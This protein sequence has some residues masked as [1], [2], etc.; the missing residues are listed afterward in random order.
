[1]S[2][3]SAP[4]GAGQLPEGEQARP[5]ISVLIRSMGRPSLQAALAS[6]AAQTL[7]AGLEVVLVNAAGT[8]HPPVPGTVGRWPLRRVE[9]GRP[10]HRAAAA[11]AA[12]DAA[13]GDWLL[14]LDDDDTLDPPHLGRLLQAAQALPPVHAVYTGVRRVQADGQVEGVLDEAFDARRLWLANFLPIHAVLFSRELVG[15]GCRFDEAFEVYE[16]WDFWHQVARH[17]SLRHVDGVSATYRLV[18]DSG[19]SADRDEARSL[20]HRQRF[21]AKWLPRLDATE[22]EQVAT[23]AELTR[24]RLADLHQLHT[25]AVAALTQRDQQL[26]QVQAEAAAAHDTAA[27]AARTA[28]AALARSEQALQDER[29]AH[30]QALADQQARTAAAQAERDAVQQQLQHTQRDLQLAQADRARLDAQYHAMIGSLSWRITAPL[31]SAR[32]AVAGVRQLPLRLA[33]GVW[34]ALPLSPDQRTRVKAQVLALPGGLALARKVAPHTVPVAAPAAAPSAPPQALD[35]QQIRADAEAALGEFLLGRERIDLGCTAAE[36]VV[37]VIAIMFNQAGLTRLCLQALAKSTGV[38]FETL[39]V[40]NGSS[41]RVPQLLDRVDGATVLRPGENLGFLRAVNLAAKQARGRYLLLLNNDAMVEPGTLAAAVRR[42]DADPG[43]AAVGGPILLWDGRLQEAGSIVWR[44]GSCLGYGRG[45]DPAR[46]EYRYV[47]DVDYCSGAFLMLRHD[48]WRRLGGFDDAYA[49]AYYE[50]SDFCVRLLEGGQRIVY[51][52]AVRV[53]HFEFASEVSSGWALELQA[54]NRAL[55]VERHQTFLQQQAP[56]SAAA[57]LRARQRVQPGRQRILVIDDRVPLPWLGRGYPRA[58]ELLVTLAAEGHA[59]TFYPLLFA[60]ETWANIERVVP[61]TV[62]IA[63]DRGVSGLFDFLQQR[64]GCFDT[65][66]VSRPHNMREF[67]QAVARDPGL[68]DGV[69]LVY[70]AEAVFALRDAELAQLQGKP[71]PDARRQQA[72]ATEMQ[73]AQGARAICAVSREEAQVFR[74]HGHAQV[75]ILGHPLHTVRDTP[76]FDT[77]SG[78]VFLGAMPEDN[79]PNTDSVLWFVNEVWP[80]IVAAAGSSARLLLVGLC[81]APS[82]LALRAPGLTVLGS[83][84]AVAPYLDQARVFIVPTRYAAGIPHKAHEAAARGLP[85]V[86]TPLIARQL[87]WQDIV[88][89]GADAASFAAGC[90]QLHDDAQRWQHMRQQLWSAVERDCAPAAFRDAL[91]AAITA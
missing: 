53:R 66:V 20:A 41:D 38:A 17:G 76:G 65:L 75:S 25:Q 32:A 71:W 50:E 69:R 14:F 63:L 80:Q 5:V 59:V 40:D 58:C 68:L 84:D 36:P 2:Q 85:M 79:T 72:V 9:P 47:R 52:P 88:H 86:T 60:H 19:L 21:Y 48:A 6:V 26:A 11:N 62:E 37:S 15:R 64:R 83:V 27:A 51:D 7:Q 16:D 74:Q 90:L 78:Y 31:R 57:L 54:R 35:K 22:A 61:E 1:M 45:D 34:R 49:P 18:G 77:R 13:Q 81:E 44:D 28:A 39:L 3:V 24:G 33:R 67:R 8:P 70:D 55:F 29:Q 89:V 82:V 4:A 56:A 10:L 91:H 23:Y 30:A 12:L 42:L 73:L 46:P 43:A 87:G